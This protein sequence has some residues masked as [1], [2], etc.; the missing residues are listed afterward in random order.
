VWA[1]AVA[2]YAVTAQGADVSFADVAGEYVAG[3]IDTRCTLKVTRAGRYS[4]RCGDDLPHTGTAILAGE[5]RLSIVV[6]VY[7]PPIT[8]QP[9]MPRIHRDPGKQPWPP[10]LED[11]TAPRV[12]SENVRLELMTLI[13]LRWG[14]RRYL[15]R[16]DAVGEFCRSIAQG[17]EPR[18]VETGWEF[19]RAGDHRKKAGKTRPTECD[20]TLR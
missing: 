16:N 19:L 13:P 10:L 2:G 15:V 14:S 7:G 20:S 18:S 9:L 1:L 12:A 5:R 6:P 17:I 8:G 3:S 4:F 11:P